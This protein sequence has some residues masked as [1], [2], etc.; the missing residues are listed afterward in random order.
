MTFAAGLLYMRLLTLWQ[1][2]RS[3][4][5]RVLQNAG[6]WDESQVWVCHYV[7][8][9]A[10]MLLI[11]KTKGIYHNHSSCPGLEDAPNRVSRICFKFLFL[12]SVPTFVLHGLAQLTT[13]LSHQ[14]RAAVS[15]TLHSRLVFIF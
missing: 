2:V 7:S 9:L 10:M 1:P 14:G 11:Y 5:W 4:V 8:F 13:R 3:K 12:P 6:A 15:H